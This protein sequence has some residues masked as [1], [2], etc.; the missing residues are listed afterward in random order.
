MKRAWDRARKIPAVGFVTELVGLYFSKRVSRA[1]AELAYFLT[2]TFF[3][4]LICLS[5]FLKQLN[6]DLATMLEEANYLLPDSVIAI[7][8]DYLNYLNGNQ[9]VAMFI[10]GIFLAVLFASA[11]MRGL[12]NIMHEIYGRATFLGLRQIGASV[13]FSV[14]LLVTVYLSL[15]VVVTGNWFLHLLGQVL[16]LEDLVERL[17][18]WQ[19][20]KYVLLIAMVFLFILLLYCFTAPWE[21]PRPPVVPG[22]VAAAIALTVASMIF[23]EI[24]GNSARYS[25]VYGSLT[26]VII[27]LVW[28]YLCGNVVVMGN[29]VNYVIYC[30]RKEK[31]RQDGKKEG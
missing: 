11:A 12:M 3:P 30:H 21:K 1:A 9:S 29:V 15:A 7:F 23:S 5:A 31:R 17:G 24:M 10:T 13:L 26:S 14:L 6:L 25:L 4:I 2:L 27:L 19:W 20:V 28:L 8:R 16:R 22:A 18:P